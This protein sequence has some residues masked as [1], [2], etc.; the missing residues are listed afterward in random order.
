[1]PWI[2]LVIAT[3]LVMSAVTL[4]LALKWTIEEWPTQKVDGGDVA[5]LAITSTLWPVTIFV[6]ALSFKKIRLTHRSKDEIDVS[7]RKF[8][9]LPARTDRA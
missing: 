7:I 8:F 3:Y 6:M 5:I 2:Y 9:R 4:R 1:M